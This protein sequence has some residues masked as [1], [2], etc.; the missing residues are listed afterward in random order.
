MKS[1]LN[2]RYLLK[3]SS[4]SLAKAGW[5]LTLT[6]N[7]ALKNNE[8][9]S[10]ASSTVLRMIDKINGEDFREKEERIKQLKQELGLL[11]NL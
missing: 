3:V 5:N 2:N 9:V 1:L 4:T 10:L 7:E 6:R 8:L 11:K